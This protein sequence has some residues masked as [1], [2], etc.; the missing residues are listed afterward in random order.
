MAELRDYQHRA[1]EMLRASF[2][3]GARAPLLV[4]PT[5]AGKTIIAAEI[6]RSAAARGSRVLFLAPRRELVRQASGKLHAV[7]IDHGVI[8]AGAKELERPYERVQV[9][10]VDTLLS[11]LMRAPEHRRL[12]LP[13]FDLVIIDEAHLAPTEKRSELLALWPNAKLVGLTA[14]PARKDGRALGTLFDAL[15][16]PTTPADL[17]SAGYLVPARYWSLT[18][19]DLER[20]QVRGGDY[21]P[22]DLQRAMNRPKLVGDVAETWLDKARDRRT[23]V[24]ASGV[25]HSIALAERFQRLGVAAEHVDGETDQRERK[26]VFDRF[27]DGRLQV[28]VNCAIATF[29]LDVPAVSCIVLARPTRSVPLYLQMLG[30]G[31]RTA[32]GK[33]DCLVL[34]HAGN[35]LVHGPA[36]EPRAWTLGGLQSLAAQERPGATESDGRMVECRECHALYVGLPAC[37]E[38]GYRPPPRGRDVV[39]V[40]GS[41]VQVGGAAPDVDGI[42]VRMQFYCEL[43]GHAVERNFK[44]GFAAHKYRERYG[45]AP[46]WDWRHLAPSPPS[47]ETARW[48]KSR[49]IAFARTKG[50]RPWA[51]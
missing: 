38:C 24:F 34:D 20:V 25:A 1:I 36:I 50:P 15:I 33:T 17:T 32:P 3:G 45:V 11:R 43:L 5:G 51:A 10:S 18:K 26:D 47:M 35:V 12:P 39:I 37:P 31:L 28:L 14:T 8:L 21:A 27:D 7:G 30:R 46:P 49:Q 19:P 16:E 23:I 4:L 22:G 48:L 42:A 44:L 6:V 9:A 29:G 2:E 41:L 13:D 40:P